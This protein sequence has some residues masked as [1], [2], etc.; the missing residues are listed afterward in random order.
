MNRALAYGRIPAWV[1]AALLWVACALAGAQEY[2]KV[3]VNVDPHT[4]T[5]GDRVK[6]TLSIVAPNLA[7][8]AVNDPV[9]DDAAST[10]G[11]LRKDIVPDEKVNA[12][13]SRR[14]I[15][16]LLAAFRTGD[17]QT[18]EFMISYKPAKGEPRE[19]KSPTEVVK[20]QSVLPSGDIS[21]L[22]MVEMKPPVTLQW[23][24]WLL[25]TL[26]GVCSALALL[27]A[28]IIWRLTR[29]KIQS[30]VHAPK[31]PDTWALEELESIERERLV[32]QKKVKEFYT[33]VSDTVRAYMGRL[34]NVSALDLTS[35]E[36]LDTL[37][38]TRLNQ[39]GH[40]LLAEVLEEADMVKFAKLRP[41]GSECRRSL[42]R[43]RDLVRATSYLA[44]PEQPQQTSL[45]PPVPVQ[46]EAKS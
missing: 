34:L 42:E 11:L 37:K 30:I 19:V 2:P 33:R 26:G 9:H 5:V 45:Q 32:E 31:D 29:R 36:L 4:V 18:P 25:W 7:G 20:V 12:T 28:V 3:S 40:D 46:P 39:R 41:D 8:V 44:H 27:A 6:L 21:K 17:I 38:D 35:S 22:K 13:E 10:W 43:G 24:R 1:L 14:T 15:Q 23:P 16:Y